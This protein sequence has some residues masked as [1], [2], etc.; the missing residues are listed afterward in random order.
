MWLCTFGHLMV[1]QICIMQSSFV[2]GKGIIATLTKSGGRLEHFE[3]RH[4]AIEKLVY[5]AEDM[6]VVIFYQLL[7]D[8][9]MSKIQSYTPSMN[10]TF[11][12]VNHYWSHQYRAN[13][14]S[15]YNN[16]NPI[17]ISTEAGAFT[18]GYKTMCEF[19]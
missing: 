12:N 3:V 1:M 14:E 8:D 16:P 18:S 2:Y 15:I 17:C 19:W 4:K 5:V 13:K 9:Q 7:T 11:V 10:I 6:D